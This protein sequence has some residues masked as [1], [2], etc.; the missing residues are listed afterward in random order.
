VI[1]L[2]GGLLSR[3]NWLVTGGG[4]GPV[5]ASETYSEHD[6]FGRPEKLTFLDGTFERTDYD[7]CCGLASTT[8]RDG[9]VTEYFYDNFRR[10]VATRALSVTT[11]NLFDD[12]GRLAVVKRKGS[13]NTI[14]NIEQML[15]DQ[16]GRITKSTNALGGVTT[17]SEGL[18]G[19]FLVKTNI[20]PDAG[21]KME[22]H[23]LDGQV[24]KITGSAVHPVRYDHGIESEGG[25]WRAYSTEYKLNADG[26]DS[27]EWTKTYHDGAGRAYKTVYSSATTPNPTAESIYNNKDQLIRQINPDSVSTVYEYNPKGEQEYIVQDMNRNGAKDLTTAGAADDR[28]AQTVR[29]VSYREV[30]DVRRT[31][32]YVWTTEDNGTANILVS[33]T[34][35]AVNGLRTWNTTHNGGASIV[36]RTE[37]QIPTSANNWTRTIIQFQPDNSK[38]I[39]LYQTGRLVSVTRKDS[40]DAQIGQTL[41]AYDAHGRQS[42]MTDVRNGTTTYTFNNADQIVSVATPPPGNGQ[43]AQ[44]T[45]TYYNKMLQA[46]NIVQPDGTSVTNK[47]FQ[48]GLLEKTLGS[49]TYPVAYTYDPQGRLK[50]MTT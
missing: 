26:T 13:D 39:S 3:T 15:Y 19:G 49:R 29:D 47:F 16:A 22:T 11:S 1:N 23:F 37:V 12:A 6:D 28:I 38:T 32:T 14:I 7:I 45:T 48:T 20:F 33:T 17:I 40:N 21:V 9:K 43:P 25:H 44:T 27:G 5:L 46:T 36:R 42:T 4:L 35:A 24:Q 30:Y 41:Y 50:T 2:Q 18:N 34:E 31:R 8:D 10:V